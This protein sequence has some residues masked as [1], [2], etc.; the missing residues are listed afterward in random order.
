MWNLWLQK[1]VWQQIFLHRSL[2]LLFLDPG[3]VKIRIRD[4]HPGSATLGMLIDTRMRVNN[5]LLY[6]G[7]RCARLSPPPACPL[8]WWPR[9]TRSTRSRRSPSL[10]PTNSRPS[11]RPRRP[12]ASSACPAPGPTWPRYQFHAPIYYT[13]ISIHKK[14]PYISRV[15]CL[16]KSIFF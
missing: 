16:L 9:A 8:S 10:S 2:L 12:S 3:W 6:K 5:C 14:I 15:C 1:K 13:Y 11:R 7:T 4:K